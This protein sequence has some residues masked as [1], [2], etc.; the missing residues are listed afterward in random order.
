MVTYP[1]KSHADRDEAWAQSKTNIIC[2]KIRELL[3]DKDLK[4]YINTILTTHLCE[5]PAD[6]EAALQSLASF[7]SEP[8]LFQRTGKSVYDAFHR[9]TPGRS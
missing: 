9:A 2:G 5:L 7:R 6:H 1:S 4:L 3:R 8:V